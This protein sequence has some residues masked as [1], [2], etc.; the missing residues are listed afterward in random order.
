[1]NNKR[2]SKRHKQSTR[3]PEHTNVSIVLCILV[4]TKR[5]TDVR[6]NKRKIERERENE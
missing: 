4:F 2:R 5:G 3:Y 1:M 6:T